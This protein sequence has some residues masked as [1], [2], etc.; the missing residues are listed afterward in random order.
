MSNCRNIMGLIH[1]I[2]YLNNYYA[3]VDLVYDLLSPVELLVTVHLTVACL[4][5]RFMQKIPFVLRNLFDTAY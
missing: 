5:L 1:F 2:H 4:S 3:R